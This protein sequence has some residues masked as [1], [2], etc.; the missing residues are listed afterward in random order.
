M[1]LTKL[2]TQL[3]NKQNELKATGLKTKTWGKVN[4]TNGSCVQGTT[5]FVIPPLEQSICAL[6]NTL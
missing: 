6:F 1:L 5:T 3:S 4:D 2:I